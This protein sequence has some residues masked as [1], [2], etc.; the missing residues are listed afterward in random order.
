MNDDLNAFGDISRRLGIAAAQFEATTLANLVTSNPTMAEDGLALFCTTHGNIAATGAAPSVST[1]SDARLA[2]RHQKGIGGG[3][4]SV[5]PLFFVVPPELE[6]VADQLVFTINPIQVADVNP[7]QKLRVITEPR[8]PAYGWYLTASPAEID[9]LEFAYLASSPGPQLESRL[10]FEVD[11][12]ETR[13][14]LDF[15]GG[16]VDW[17]GWYYNA[18]H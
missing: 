5:T 7:F 1:L 17:R 16:F 6:T 13:V 8:L 14:R 11:G 4:I 10:G 12:L 3:P 18:G 9:G 15:G 2:M